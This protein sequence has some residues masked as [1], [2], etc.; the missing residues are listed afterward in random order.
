MHILTIIL[1]L[2]LGYF[3]GKVTCNAHFKRGGFWATLI[4][5]AIINA[6]HSFIDGASLTGT[7]AYEAFWLMIGHELIRQP[8]LYGIFL[9]IIAP[10][11]HSWVSR[12]SIAVLA[13]TG[14]WAAAAFLGTLF[15]AELASITALEPY[16]IYFQYLFIGDIIHH[17]V[18]WFVHRHQKKYHTH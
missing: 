6:L 16:L 18:D 13:V 2:G 11:T 4:L 5:F 15:G 7:K 1:F 3:L 10:F 14:V 9:G 12:I 17:V 8:V